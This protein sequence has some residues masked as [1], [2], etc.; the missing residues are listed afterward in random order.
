M[1]YSF[2][3]FIY[4]G[5]FLTLGAI[6]IQKVMLT[7][8]DRTLLLLAVATIPLYI[9]FTIKGALEINRIK[10]LRSNDGGWE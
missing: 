5:F 6:L 3:I 4:V 8:G 10:R 2:F 9:Y 7:P 1:K